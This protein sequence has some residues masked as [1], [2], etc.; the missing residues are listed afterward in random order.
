M[1]FPKLP[2]MSRGEVLSKNSALPST[3]AR[4]SFESMKTTY[5]SQLSMLT[6]LFPDWN[7]E[8]LV[9]VIVELNGDLELAVNR[10]TEGIYF[11]NV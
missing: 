4:N 1:K 3:K 11:R 5:V 10:I 9:A 6:E 7:E 8:D 2:G